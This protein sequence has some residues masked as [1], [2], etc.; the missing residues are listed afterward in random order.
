[1]RIM[2][3][4]EVQAES[5]PLF[6]ECLKKVNDSLVKGIRTFFSSNNKSDPTSI[7]PGYMTQIK[8]SLEKS[9][10]IVET[11]GQPLPHGF[12]QVSTPKE[13]AQKR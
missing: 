3:P 5:A 9:G 13:R 6:E 1:M 4:D 8:S 2:T 10:W 12:I 11:L 7:P